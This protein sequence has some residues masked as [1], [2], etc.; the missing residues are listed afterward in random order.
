MGKLVYGM[1]VSLDGYIEDASGSFAWSRPDDEVHRLA[2]EH[3][4]RA[5]AFVYGRRLYELME[6]SWPQ[7]AGRDDLPEVEAEFAKLYVDTPRIVVSDSLSSV[8]AGATLVRRDEA[9]AEVMRLKDD[10]DGEI[11]VGG[12]ELA[13]ALI[14]LID[15]FLLFVSPVAVGGGKP[16]FPRGHDRVDLEL[17]EVRT[18]ASG[19]V[20]LRYGRAAA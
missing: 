4:R 15:E 19:V 2:N 3:A 10:A 9:V 11:D 20:Y 1:G 5:Q 14:D 7:L 16:F 6:G 17:L 12:A 8:A 18:F 13:A